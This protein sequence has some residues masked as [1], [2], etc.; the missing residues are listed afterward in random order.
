LHFNLFLVLVKLAISHLLSGDIA[1]VFSTHYSLVICIINRNDRCFLAAT[2]SATTATA[3]VKASEN[4]EQYESRT[5]YTQPPDRFTF[6]Q[7]PY[8]P[9]RVR[10]S[11]DLI[12]ESSVSL[13]CTLLAGVR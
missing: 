12:R 10:S 5:S 8:L 3:A 4:S 11:D 6:I 1:V 13:I 7:K 9:D 2:F